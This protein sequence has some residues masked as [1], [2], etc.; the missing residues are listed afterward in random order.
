MRK[1]IVILGVG[2]VLA[3]GALAGAQN[4]SSLRASFEG[5][6]VKGG[7]TS[8]RN[9]VIEV[10]GMQLTAERGVMLSENE[11][12]LEGIVKLRALTPSVKP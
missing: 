8:L 7:Q 12:Q 2:A 3:M 6:A 9:I 1:R 11:M 4:I 5:V 10:D